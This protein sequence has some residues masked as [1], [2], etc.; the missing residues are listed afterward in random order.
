MKPANDNAR[1]LHQRLTDITWWP[2]QLA[3][4]VMSFCVMPGLV[5]AWRALIGP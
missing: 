2:V 3:I 1:T 5:W 4:F